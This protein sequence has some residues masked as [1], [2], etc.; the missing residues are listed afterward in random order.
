MYI[1]N[2][3]GKTICDTKGTKDYI[4]S[5]LGIHRMGADFAGHPTEKSKLDTGTLPPLKNSAHAP[6][7]YCTVHSISTF[8]PVLMTYL[9]KSSEIRELCH[10]SSVTELLS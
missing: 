10:C 6:T 5:P 8:S 2:V 9:M 4:L 1:V 7:L 3:L